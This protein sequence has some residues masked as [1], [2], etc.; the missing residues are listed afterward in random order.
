MSSWRVASTRTFARDHIPLGGTLEFS[1]PMTSS[2][3][4]KTSS[5]PDGRTEMPKESVVKSNPISRIGNSP[6][7]FS[8][9]LLQFLSAFCH[10]HSVEALPHQDP[11]RFCC[12]GLAACNNSLLAVSLLLTCNSLRLNILRITPLFPN[13]CAEIRHCP[14]TV[15]LEIMMDTLITAKLNLQV[16]FALK[17]KLANG[18][19]ETAH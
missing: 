18:R 15:S 12:H 14:E 19:V 3:S 10:S 11:V 13:T 7:G 6:H 17:Q 4:V 16:Y 9:K 2:D 5:S 1:T 8:T